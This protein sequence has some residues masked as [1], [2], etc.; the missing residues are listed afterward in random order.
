MPPVAVTF[1]LP[2]LPPKQLTLDDEGMVAV[3]RGGCVIT[4]VS[5]LGHPALSLTV[6]IY[7]PA[8]RPVAV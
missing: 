5:L 6:T 2:L 7:V 1:A 4:T 3:R 8:E